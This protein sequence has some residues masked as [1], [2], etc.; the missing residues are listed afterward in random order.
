[1]ENDDMENKCPK[2]KAKI[3]EPDTVKYQCGSAT[4]GGNSDMYQSVDCRVRELELLLEAMKAQLRP[5]EKR[6]E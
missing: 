2:C 4:F 3:K 1:M 5:Q 6:D